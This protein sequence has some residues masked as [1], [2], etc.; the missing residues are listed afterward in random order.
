MILFSPQATEDPFRQARAGRFAD[1]KLSYIL[2]ERSHLIFSIHR[3]DSWAPGG[4]GKSSSAAIFF[5]MRV[6]AK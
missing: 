2:R 6:A 3:L 5:P 1:D 4:C